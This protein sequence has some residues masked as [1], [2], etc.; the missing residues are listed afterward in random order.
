MESE[1]EKKRLTVIISVL[2]REELLPRT[3]DSILRQ[4]F[5]NFELIIVD[6]GSDDGTV[7][8]I[9]KYL[10][11]L[12]EAGIETRWMEERKRGISA[13][14]NKG[15]TAVGTE[16]VM[17]FDSDDEME[18]WHLKSIHEELTARP[19]TDLLWFDIKEVDEEGWT[20]VRSVDDADIMRGHILHAT[21]GSARFAVSTELIR[22]LGGFD[23]SILAWEDLELGVRLLC[24]AKSARKLNCEP[25]MRVYRHEDSITGSTFS[26]KNGDIEHAMDLCEDA[27]RRSGRQ[28]DT[29][30]VDVKRMV[31]AGHYAREGERGMSSRLSDK[32]LDRTARARNRIALGFVRDT[33]AYFGRGG[34]AIGKA[35]VRKDKGSKGE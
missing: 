24:A 2:N 19:A 5:K 26:S 17:F 20:K 4:T 27:L 34:C 10:P 14:R 3:L 35:L 6:N 1:K 11:K 31:V 12:K 21:L 33:V 7:R 23:E 32:V 30:W 18:P 16:W 8:V 13:A 25:G 22:S 9:E 15:L 29:V 28:E